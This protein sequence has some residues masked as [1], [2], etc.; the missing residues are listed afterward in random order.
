MA[1]LD[2]RTRKA[3]LL[4]KAVMERDN[5]TCKKCGLSPDE[6][7]EKYDG[8]YTIYLKDKWLEID[9]IIP[10]SKG[11]L[12]DLDNLQVLCNSCNVKKGGKLDGGL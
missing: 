5:F 2:F 8:K 1:V 9:H 3:K 12:N 11:G 4:R 10:R 7:I 6:K